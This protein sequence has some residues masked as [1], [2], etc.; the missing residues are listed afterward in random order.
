MEI[1]KL[2]SEIKKLKLHCK[3]L[4]EE[5]EFYHRAALDAKRQN[6]IL[7]V[8][9]GR[10][11]GELE[12]KKETINKITEV[13]KDQIMDDVYTKLNKVASANL[14]P[15]VDTFL[16]SMKGVHDKSIELP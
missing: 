2:K 13:S 3:T 15:D 7:K 16:T 5:K 6:K 12:I 11:Q 14:E 1:G 9:F 4:D 10:L 8:A